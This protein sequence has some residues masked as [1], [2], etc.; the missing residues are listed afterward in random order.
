MGVERRVMPR[1]FIRTAV[2][3][4]T[5]RGIQRYQ[6]FNL[7][8]GG[9]YLETD[10][11]LPVGSQIDLKF[12]LPGAGAVQ[13]KGVVKHHQTLLIDEK[14]SGQSELHGMGISFLRIEGDGAQAL[15]EQVKQLTL[16][17]R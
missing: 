14:G 9:I 10:K 5:T 4:E 8:A 2:R 15:A 13:A 7:S 11:P 1:A 16:H 12:D 17:T 6:S 3:V